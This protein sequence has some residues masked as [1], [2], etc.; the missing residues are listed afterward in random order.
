M[1]KPVKIL[2]VRVTDVA[3][4]ARALSALVGDGKG[5]K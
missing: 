5:R 2:W 3:A 1:P 4:A